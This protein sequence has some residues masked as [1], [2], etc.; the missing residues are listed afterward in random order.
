MSQSSYH[1][2]HHGDYN[3]ATLPLTMQSATIVWTYPFRGTAF[4]RRCH[5][6]NTK[7]SFLSSSG[8]TRVLPLL[9]CIQS[10]KCAFDGVATTICC[11]WRTVSSYCLQLTASSVISIELTSSLVVPSIPNKDHCHPTTCTLLSITSQHP[12]QS[13]FTINWDAAEAVSL[14]KDACKLLQFHVGLV[15]ICEKQTL[16]QLMHIQVFHT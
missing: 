4:Q 2:G 11:T 9:P 6:S 16:M 12:G 5:N 13:Y 14:S 10:V 1:D 3:H 15:M 7:R 8:Y